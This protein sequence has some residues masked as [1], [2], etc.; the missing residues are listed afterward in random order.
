MHARLQR[1]SQPRGPRRPVLAAAALLALGLAAA[2]A[3][4]A[5]ALDDAK[6]AGLVGEQADGYLG[7]VKGEAPSDV[8]KLVE[9][10]N[11][12]RRDRYTEIAQK[13]GASLT[14][15]SHLAGAKLIARTPPGQY[16]RTVDGKW[17]KKE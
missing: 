6:S 3:A 15:V 4:G 1:I 11:A 14:G 5:D 12:E 13:N 2:P 8:V 10:T 9:E 7:L 17:M 16:V